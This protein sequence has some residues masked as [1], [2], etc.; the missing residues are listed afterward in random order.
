MQEG[1]RAGEVRNHPRGFY[2]PAVWCEQMP[3]KAKAQ[4]RRQ[5]C[6]AKVC[7][8]R[9]RLLCADKF[10]NTYL[11]DTSSYMHRAYHASKTRPFCTK[12]GVPCAGT[13]QFK[14]MVECLLRDSVGQGD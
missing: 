3:G 5:H 7:A 6:Q 10:M 9:W 2:R 12:E 8:R 4:R 14:I 13:H 11:L 1:P